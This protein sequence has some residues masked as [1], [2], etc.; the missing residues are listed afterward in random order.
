VVIR[1][2]DQPTLAHPSSD[3]TSQQDDPAVPAQRWPSSDGSLDELLAGP[4]SPAIRD[5]Q[6]AQLVARLAATDD[7]DEDR[8]LRDLLVEVNM[9]VAAALATRYRRRGEPL[10]DLEQVAYLALVRASRRFKPEVGATFVGFC[11]PTILGEVKRHFR[12]RGWMVRPPRR[13]QELQLRVFRA[14][15]ELQ[16]ELG[17]S[18]TVPELA[19]RTDCGLEDIVEVLAVGSC[20]SPTPLDRPVGEDNDSLP[21][22]ELLPHEDEDRDA[23]DARVMLAP[24]VRRLGDRDRRVLQL[25]FFDGLTQSEIARDIGVTQMQVSRVLSRIFAELREGIGQP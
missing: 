21:L 22:A 15:S 10:E 24:L 3:P 23:A 20:Y 17:R 7:P 18:P 11:V 16:S 9:P 25:R 1:L 13:V 6:S 2:L 5:E 4:T 14:R 19:E 12:D 8:R